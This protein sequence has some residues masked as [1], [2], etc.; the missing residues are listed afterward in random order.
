M[1]VCSFWIS[2]QQPELPSRQVTNE[3]GPTLLK[4]PTICSPQHVFRG[5]DLSYVSNPAGVRKTG[6]IYRV[7]SQIPGNRIIPCEWKHPFPLLVITL[8][9]DWDN[10]LCLQFIKQPCSVP[11]DKPSL[12][13][14]FYTAL[15]SSQ[16]L[17][18][19]IL[20]P[21]CAFGRGE[22]TLHDSP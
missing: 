14:T 16:R 11:R 4:K 15:S 2:H 20:T 1:S 22:N 6:N 10:L 18:G 21:R 7:V 3:K 5:R 8:L 9:W 17:L 19:P 13:H 12:H